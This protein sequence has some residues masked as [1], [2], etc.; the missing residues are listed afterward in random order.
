MGAVLLYTISTFF[1]LCRSD[2]PILM[3]D[4]ELGDSN[5]IV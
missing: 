3:K 4:K 5:M 1:Y 2:L